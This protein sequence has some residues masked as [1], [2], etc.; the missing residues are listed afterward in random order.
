MWLTVRKFSSMCGLG[1]VLNEGATRDKLMTDSH[2]TIISDG[3]K[4]LFL[5]V[6]KSTRKIRLVSKFVG[7]CDTE[8][9]G[10]N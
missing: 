10:A 6:R 7:Q 8:K 5:I 1:G 2:K 4:K 3:Q 9:V